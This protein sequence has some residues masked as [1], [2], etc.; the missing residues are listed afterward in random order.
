MVGICYTLHV[1]C[2]IPVLVGW[3]S[4]ST[5]PK[6][7]FDVTVGQPFVDGAY[8]DI[9]ILEHLKGEDQATQALSWL[10]YPHAQCCR[11]AS[12]RVVV[13]PSCREIIGVC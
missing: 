13:R 8:V 2:A 9:T 3:T 10:Q 11:P 7:D 1:I 6:D 12:C 4:T 5:L